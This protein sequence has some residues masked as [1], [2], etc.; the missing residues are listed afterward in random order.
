VV[1]ASPEDKKVAMMHFSQIYPFSERDRF[2][3]VETL[4]N[5]DIAICIENNASGQFAKLMRQET[6]FEFAHQIIKY[7]GRPFTVEELKE[8]LYAYI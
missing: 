1:D 7:D 8:D 5:A 6:G 2:D 4:E 3:Y